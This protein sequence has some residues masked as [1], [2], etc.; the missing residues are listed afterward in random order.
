MYY[1]PLTCIHATWETEKEINNPLHWSQPPWKGS[2]MG[3]TIKFYV[4][5]VAKLL[6][7]ASW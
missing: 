2:E 6:T 5:D 1:L 3:A 7:T 4:V